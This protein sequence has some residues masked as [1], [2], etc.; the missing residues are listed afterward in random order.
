MDPADYQ[1]T[2]VPDNRI[3]ADTRSFLD[4]GAYTGWQLFFLLRLEGLVRMEEDYA[5]SVEVSG[6]E[7]A[8]K[9]KLLR[10]A[11]YSTYRDCIEQEVGDIAKRLFKHL[12]TRT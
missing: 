6:P 3:S 10:K 12:L 1:N 5:K 8:V 9:L 7:G 11:I 2:E 4:K